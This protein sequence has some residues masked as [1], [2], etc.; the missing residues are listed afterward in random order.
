MKKLG[1]LIALIAVLLGP[2]ASSHLYAASYQFPDTYKTPVTPEM[3]EL[4]KISK[5]I[6]AVAAVTSN[7]LVFISISKTIQGMPLQMVDPFE[8]FFGMPRPDGGGGGRG[9]PP[10]EM[11]KQ[12]GLG[13]GFIIDLDKGYI[14]TNNHVIEGADEISLKLANG[15]VY[16]GVVVGRDKNTDIAVVRIKDA[17][18]DKSK[19]TSLTLAN[20]DAVSVGDLV[21]AAGAPFG[22]ESSVSFGVV[23]A[24]GRGSL[25]ITKIG[26]FIQTD[27]AINPGN[28]GGPLLNM[29]GRVIGVN[30]AIFSKSGAYNGIGFAVPSNIVKS[31]GEKLINHGKV[32]RGF[33]GVSLQTLDKELAESLKLS[34]DQ[35]GA[36]IANV[37]KGG[38]A[39]KSGIREGDVI[40]EV[41]GK[42]VANS[43]DVASRIGIRGAGESVDLGIFREGKRSNMK[44][45]LGEFPDED[46]E[47]AEGGSKDSPLGMSVAKVNDEMRRRYNLETKTGVVVLDM[48][49]DS[50]G[51]R[52]GIQPGDAIISVNNKK[53]DSVEDFRKLAS[54][55]GRLLMRLE[56]QG[57]YF[58]VSIRK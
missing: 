45:K 27:A 33:I 39:D 1:M 21:V 44:V 30:S 11:P 20:S 57:Q 13:S 46:Q 28:S 37:Q 42:S 15:K 55:S 8:F 52:A 23:S 54:G 49:Q 16:D 53:I 26:N 17:K 58:F 12:Q 51:A 47:V 34:K 3:Q 43:D 6:S 4:Q 7:A 5:G 41:D 31:V 35:S 25:G 2:A 29:E 9:Q 19:L 48:S 32:S 18:F 22:L 50:L 36:L 40:V 24:T 56:R 38:P 10:R 14:V